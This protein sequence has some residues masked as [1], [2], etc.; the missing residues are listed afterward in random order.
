MLSILCLTHFL[1]GYVYKA[2]STVPLLVFAVTGTV[3]TMFV[4]KQLVRCMRMLAIVVIT[5]VMV[6]L[7]A[8]I[9]D[10]IIAV[11]VKTVFVVLLLSFLLFELFT[12]PAFVALG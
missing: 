8:A 6:V 10:F 7:T 11:I 12:T 2:T 3:H 5:T 4:H 9:I 1:R